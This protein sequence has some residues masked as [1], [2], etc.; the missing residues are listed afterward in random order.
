MDNYIVKDAE[1]KGKDITDKYNELYY[2]FHS[3]LDKIK[4]NW[5]L[6]QKDQS[7][8]NALRE[9]GWDDVVG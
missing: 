4:Q 1:N 6:N 2:S 3:I 9:N 5:K 7:I 8:K